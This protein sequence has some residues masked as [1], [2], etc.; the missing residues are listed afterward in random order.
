MVHVPFF[1]IVMAILVILVGFALFMV[2]GRNIGAQAQQDDALKAKKNMM[3]RLIKKEEALK[4]T[5]TLKTPPP[6]PQKQ[7]AS[8]DYIGATSYQVPETGTELAV[9]LFEVQKRVA[10]FNTEKFL[11]QV[12]GCFRNVVM[13]FTEGNRAALSPILTEELLA[14]FDKIIEERLR[15]GEKNHSD[16]RRLE[17]LEIKDVLFLEDEVEICVAITSWQV[18]YKIN[19]E[20]RLIEGTEGLTEF[21]DLWSFTYCDNVASEGKEP[22]WRL[23]KT[24]AF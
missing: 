12:D 22:T 3:E 21:R 23:K 11:R 19:R 10:Q 6:L 5:Q 18:S 1:I 7:M 9:K 8:I 14:I 2:L 16:I 24:E 13:G 20:K 15:K 17:S 4:G